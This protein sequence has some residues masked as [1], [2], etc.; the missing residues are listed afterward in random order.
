MTIR[1]ISATYSA[2]I[3]ADDIAAIPNADDRD[4]VKRHASFKGI[5]PTIT[6]FCARWHVHATV[7]EGR[8]IIARV[9]RTG[10]ITYR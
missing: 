2:K 4:Y 9:G 5:M 8:K 1:E 10:N 6:D 7:R 3:D